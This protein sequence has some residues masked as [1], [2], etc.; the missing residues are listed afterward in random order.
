[1]EVVALPR[2]PL[3]HA[4]VA[5]KLPPLKFAVEPLAPDTL[6]TRMPW[7]PSVMVPPVWVSVLAAFW[8]MIAPDVAD[9]VMLPP[10]ICRT[11]ELP[12][13]LPSHRT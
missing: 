13:R 7:L 10:S 3:N 2:T 6:A 12:A 1:M 8:P 11:P 5:L 9:P 4:P